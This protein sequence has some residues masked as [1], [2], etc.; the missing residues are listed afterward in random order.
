MTP[1]FVAR[2]DGHALFVRDWGEGQPEMFARGMGDGFAHLGR[3]D[4]AAERGRTS[5]SRLRPLRSRATDWG[6]FD[7]DAFAD[8]LGAVLETLDL[9]REKRHE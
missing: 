5:H 2:G 1:A 6:G 4:A 3:D 9:A 8:D 7:C